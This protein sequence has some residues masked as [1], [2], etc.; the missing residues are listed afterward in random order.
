MEKLKNQSLLEK[1]DELFLSALNNKVFSGASIA[2]S[3]VNNEGVHRKITNYGFTHFN[4]TKKVINNRTFFDL[5]S[6]T[7][8][9]VT[10]TS[11]LI[12]QKDGEISINDPISK[13]YKNYNSKTKDIKVWQLLSHCSGL[14]AHR[15]YFKI[16][17]KTL[18]N[19]EKKE[20][21]IQAI[22]DENLL[23][24]PGEKCVY[25]DL[26]FILLGNIIEKVS[27]QKLDKYWIKNICEPLE[28]S[29]ELIFPV[30]LPKKNHDF[31][32]TGKCS[33]SGELLNGIVHDDNCR[34]IGGV[35]GHAGL[36]GTNKGLA[37][38]CESLLS[39]LKNLK[40][41]SIFENSELLNWVKKL[42]GKS[43]STGFDTP[44]TLGS[45]CGKKFSKKSIGHLGFT[46]VSFWIDFEKGINISL[47][48]NRVISDESNRAIKIFRPVI[49]DVIMEHL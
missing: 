13:F 7:K 6:L 32:V 1:L 19:N 42:D 39:Q 37:I 34:F 12:L 21:I 14:P 18:S 29:D 31:A 9:L 22:L 43:W 48:T 27:G 11:L 8:P 5:A 47:L 16:F 40:G 10:V 28:L 23:S 38:F 35:A 26:G 15:E 24:N 44:T 25:S 17:S 3:T 49:H 45:S 36:F 33:W 4:E 46:G 30:N 20:K 2:I 41:N